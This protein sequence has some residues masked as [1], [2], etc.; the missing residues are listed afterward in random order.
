MPEGLLK[1]FPMEKREFWSKVACDEKNIQEIRIREQMPIFINRQGTEWYLDKEG[2]YTD[3]YE[4]AYWTRKGEVGQVLQHICQYSIYAFED[5]LRQGY[6]TVAGGYRIGVAGQTVLETNKTVRTIKHISYLNIRITHQIKGAG[7][8]LL[9]LIYENGELKNTLIISPPGCGKTTLL[10]DLVRQVSNGNRYAK[11]KCVGV[12]D[13][14]S[15]IAGCFQGKPQNDIGIRTDVLDSCPKA[16]GMMMLLRAMSPQV[17]AVDEL[18]SE[19]DMEAVHMAASC[20]SRLLATIHGENLE[21]IQRKPGM[22]RVLQEGIFE[23]FVVLGKQ[24]GNCVIQ[25]IYGKTEGTT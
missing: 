8:K 2:C 12:V 9:P 14:R 13:E 15:E 1:L 5:E 24:N 11:G 10:R 25:K 19:E 23:R 3:Q 20:G 16:M 21:N 6:L 4:K 22:E 17:I 18:G 7:D